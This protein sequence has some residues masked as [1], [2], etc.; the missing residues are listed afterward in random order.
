MRG[1]SVAI[2]W[3]S[4]KSMPDGD[5]GFAGLPDDAPGGAAGGEKSPEQSKNRGQDGIG[6]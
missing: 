3:I 5:G 6:P 4:A 2:A 1:A